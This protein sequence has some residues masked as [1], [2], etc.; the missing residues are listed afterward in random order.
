MK[1]Y[2]QPGNIIDLTAPAG[3]IASG[4]AALFGALFGVATTAAEAG[5]RVAVSVEGVF[6]LPKA[7]GVSFT[8]GQKAYWNDTDKN[9]TPTASGNTLIGHAV[10]VAATGVTDINVRVSQ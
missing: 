7:A 1:N 8:E 9:V 10:E 3:G 6:N 5:A 4:H 2:V